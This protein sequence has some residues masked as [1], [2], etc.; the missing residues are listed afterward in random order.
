MSVLKPEITFVPM[1]MIKIE[2]RTR[3]DIIFLG[4]EDIS[5]LK[6]PATLSFIESTSRYIVKFISS[7]LYSQDNL[8]HQ[9]KK[10]TELLFLKIK[11]FFCYLRQF[12]SITGSELVYTTFLVQKLI[13]SENQDFC[14]D[15]NIITITDKNM[16]TVLICAVILAMK[17]IQDVV[18][19]KNCWF[20]KAFGMNLDLLNLSEIAFFN[21]LNFSIAL[22]RKQFIRLYS[23]IIQTSES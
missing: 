9:Q 1:P 22:E 3:Y 4:Q 10:K 8:E 13:E 14:E 12:A 21:Q 11:N 23:Q 6:S 5:A 20:A 7:I 17:M 2:K 19:Y 18:E 16:G 15:K